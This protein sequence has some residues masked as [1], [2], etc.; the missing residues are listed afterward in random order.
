M[1]FADILTV[2]CC[3]SAPPT[4]RGAVPIQ[5]Q[6]ALPPWQT[7]IRWVL[8]RAF[9][10]SHQQPRR[11]VSWIPQ[12]NMPFKYPT[13]VARTHSLAM[14]TAP[15]APGL[16]ALQGPRR[17]TCSIIS[18]IRSDDIFMDTTQPPYVNHSRPDTKRRSIPSTP[19]I[20]Q[21]HVWTRCDWLWIPLK[22]S[23]TKTAAQ[24]YRT[25]PEIIN[26]SNQQGYSSMSE[27]PCSQNSVQWCQAHVYHLRRERHTLRLRIQ[28]ERPTQNV[29]LNQILVNPY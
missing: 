25:T 17:R 26:H 27:L 9:E 11:I 22:G 29:G 6:C 23:H 13:S 28:P 4:R 16:R 19:T 14:L 15:L 12:S 3:H 2:F 21:Q 20:H 1:P 7:R 24:T 5:G 18:S 10:S 8:H